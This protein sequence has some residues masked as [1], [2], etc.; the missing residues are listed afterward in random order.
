MS[1][2]GPSHRSGEEHGRTTF[3]PARAA[4]WDAACA[5]SVCARDPDAETEDDTDV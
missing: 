4:F 1:L 3:G 5:Q 2:F